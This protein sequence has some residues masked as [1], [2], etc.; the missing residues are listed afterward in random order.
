VAPLSPTRAVLAGHLVVTI[1]VLAIIASITWFGR[2]QFG[3]GRTGLA[4]L[5]GSAVAWL[6]WSFATPRWRRW[7]HSRGADPAAVQ[8][9]GAWT[10]LVWPK[11]FIA[12]RTEFRRHKPD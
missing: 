1:P 2:A 10:G 3:P 7:A 8:R 12:E 11:G 4:L 5:A 6:W 9:L